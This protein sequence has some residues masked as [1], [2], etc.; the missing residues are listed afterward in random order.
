MSAKR[1]QNSTRS[2]AATQHRAADIALPGSGRRLV[3]PQAHAAPQR[4][5]PVGHE[6]PKC[7][8]GQHVRTIRGPPGRLAHT[9]LPH[10]QRQSPG[11]KTHVFVRATHRN[12]RRVRKR[13][14]GVGIGTLELVE[15][16]ASRG[17]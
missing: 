6:R 5:P 14:I 3:G 4:A 13:I 16:E 10:S 8:V 1:H 9:E 11:G 12:Q 2:T 15:M 17:T 7:R